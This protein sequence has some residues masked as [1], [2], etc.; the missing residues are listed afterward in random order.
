MRRG[1]RRPPRLIQVRGA[2]SD[3]RQAKALKLRIAGSS[4]RQIAEALGVTV[5]SAAGL[6]NRAL[7][8]LAEETRE[9][10]IRLRS[11]ELARLDE[12]IAAHWPYAMEADAQS[13]ALVLRAIAE[14]AKIAGLYLTLGDEGRAIAIA[15][16]QTMLAERQREA[17]E[18]VRQAGLAIEL[19]FTPGNGA[20]SEP[21]PVDVT[22]VVPSDDGKNGGGE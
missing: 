6:V 10:A 21:E 1:G 7:A 11:L 5:P 14:R 9:S 2:G 4:I 19:P 16:L 15:D 18:R 22:P 20:V 8:D 12:L 13:S 3:A 17:Q